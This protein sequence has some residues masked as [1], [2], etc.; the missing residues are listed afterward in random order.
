M[1][2]QRLVVT[3]RP[4][5]GLPEERVGPAER[6][7]RRDGFGLTDP[8]MSRREIIDVMGLVTPAIIPYRRTG[9]AGVLGYLERACPDYLIIFPE[10]FP[11]LSTMPDRFKP[12]Y[13][14]RLEHNT[15]AGGDEMVVYETPWTGSRGAGGRCGTREDVP[16]AAIRKS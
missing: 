6:R 8:R 7:R 10:W 11:K 3:E 1:D 13:W 16:N 14:L 4:N 12:I 5:P 2:Y 15:V 9:D